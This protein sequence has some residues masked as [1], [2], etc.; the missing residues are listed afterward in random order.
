MPAPFPGMDPYLEQ[1]DAWHDFHEKFL[2]AAAERW[3]PRSGRI[4]SSRSTSTSTSTNSPRAPTPRRPGGRVRGPAASDGGRSPGLGVLEAPA[5]VRLPLQD[6]ERLAFL[7]VRDRHSRELV[8]V[9]ELLSPSNK[10]PGP[11]REQYLAKR[12]S[13]WAA[14]PTSSRS[15]CSAAAGRC[16]ATTARLATIPYSSAG[17]RNAPGPASGRYACANASPWS[18]S[19]PSPRRRRPARPPGDPRPRLRRLRLR[20]LYLRRITR[21]PAHA[22]GRRLGPCACSPAGGVS[23][24]PSDGSSGGLRTR[25]GSGSR[26]GRW[27][28]GGSPPARSG[29]PASRRRNAAS[30]SRT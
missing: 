22:G 20:G 14:G 9:V 10:R 3:W 25:P 24:S 23:R 8:A 15:T 27:C 13:S 5:Q 26:T 1:D 4:T 30:R 17:S 12:R 7:E 6:A 28:V 2:P 29:G 16:R 18:P 19:P 11:D 21:P